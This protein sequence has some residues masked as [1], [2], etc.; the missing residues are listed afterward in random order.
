MKEMVITPPLLNDIR[1]ESA[2]TPSRQAYSV[3]KKQNYKDTSSGDN[4]DA[5]KET[6]FL[7]KRPQISLENEEKEYVIDIL[8]GH[9]KTPK[10]T[11]YHVR[12]YG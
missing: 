1:M 9:I 4:H 5:L 3:K 8:I 11:F 7:P 12:L 2:S 6:D 10:E